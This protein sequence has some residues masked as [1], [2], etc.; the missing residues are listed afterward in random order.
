MAP[1]PNNGKK[2]RCHRDRKKN[3]NEFAFEPIQGLPAIENHFQASEGHGHRENSPSIDLQLAI[4]ARRLNLALERR[5]IG[6]MMLMEI[7]IKNSPRQ[8]QWSVFQPPSGGP[9]AGSVTIAM[10]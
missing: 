4:F 5:R 2:K 6:D 8:L 9:I 3:D 10:L 7:L 1:L